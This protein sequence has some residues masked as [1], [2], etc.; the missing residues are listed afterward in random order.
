LIGSG[1]SLVQDLETI[2]NHQDSCLIIAAYSALPYLERVGVFA[3][4][5]LCVDPLQKTHE[6]SNAHILLAAP[7]ASF[8]AQKRFEKVATMPEKFCPF[9]L[10]L[11]AS[12]PISQ[13][14]GYTVVD[15]TLRY[16]VSCGFSN[17][18]LF[19]VDLEEIDPKYPDRQ[20]KG[21][22]IDFKKAKEHIHELILEYPS[23]GFRKVFEKKPVEKKLHLKPTFLEEKLQ[24]F[25]QSL[26][27][28]KDL[29]MDNLGLLDTFKLEKE[30]FY[31][32]VLEPLYEKMKLFDQKAK[33]NKKSFFQ[34]VLCAYKAF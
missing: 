1:S 29:D 7:K 4:I 6:S 24:A 23:I 20:E 21:Y 30:P 31:E 26:D 19:G 8:E 18:S 15:M 14:F 9:S 10:Y 27:R 17:I 34:N 22:K 12:S 2:K 32:V 5:A 16:L 25:K 3:D 33:E 13:S 28:L 11:F